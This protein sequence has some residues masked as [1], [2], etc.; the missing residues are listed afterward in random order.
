MKLTSSFLTLALALLT[1]VAIANPEPQIPGID[2]N[3]LK[4]LVSSTLL[5]L[6]VQDRSLFNHAQQFAKFAEASGGTR[7]FG[8]PGHN[9]TVAYIKRQLDRTGYY[10][11][12]LQTFPYLFSEGSA[13]FAVEGRDIPTAWFTYG[14]A[15]DVEKPIVLVNN[16]GCTPEDF[17]P[18]VAGN[19][20][21]ISRGTCEFGLKTALAGAAGAAGAIIYNN[22]P[23]AVGGGTLGAVSRPDGPYVPVSSVTGEEGATLRAAVAAG[24]VIGKLHVDAVTED[25]YSS[26]L[27]ATTK[28]GDKDNIIFA[29]GHSDSVPAGPG[30]NDDG[31]GTMSILE[32]ALRLPLF[33]VNNAVRFGFWTAEEFGLVGSEHYITNL[34]QS[35]RDKIA[36]YLN[37]DMVA[38][39]N[40]GYFIYDGDGSAFG[41][42]GPPGSEH[43]EKTFED[44][45]KGKRLRSAPTEFSGRSDYGPFLDVGIPAGGLFT[46][47]EG[48]KTA[49]EAQWWGGQAGVAYDACYHQACDGVANLHRE[50]WLQNTRAAAH[51]IATYA[52][53][54]DGIPRS[55]RSVS[56]EA[57]VADLNHEERRHYACGHKISFD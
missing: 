11:T 49:E 7:A 20:A 57:R 31:S 56:A 39:P 41:L 54:I 21:L 5:Q 42:T 52:R 24:E 30:I 19:I 13:T 38:S 25:R 48:V 34:P 40:F 35:E 51:S 50:A 9:A 46:G 22:A 27:F 44:F 17:P 10:D 43:I 26:N 33:K 18:E 3:A 15:G 4:P 29:G 53:S 12:E 6:L 23:G 8:S 14:P 16:L 2:L 36:L 47:A 37:F 1:P 55:A 32:I 28:H 45:F